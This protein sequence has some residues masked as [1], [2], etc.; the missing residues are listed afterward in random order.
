MVYKKYFK[1][2]NAFSSKKK[3]QQKTEVLR[4]LKIKFY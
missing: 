4:L 3:L 1:T 2:L